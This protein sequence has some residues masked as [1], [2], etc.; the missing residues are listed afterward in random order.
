M[1]SLFRRV[2]L[3]SVLGGLLV[4]SIL[5]WMAANSIIFQPT[6][7]IV[8]REEFYNGSF[9]NWGLFYSWLAN[10]FSSF[11]AF[12]L[13][14][15]FL[16]L[17]SKCFLFSTEK[18]GIYLFFFY[19]ISFYVVYESMRFRFALAM[20]AY[21]YFLFFL[22]HS[23]YH[24]VALMGALAFLLH[25]SVAPVLL[26]SALMFTGFLRR[27]PKRTVF[28]FSMCAGIII[29]FSFGNFLTVL[30]LQS[31][32]LHYDNYFPI[33]N[34]TRY[35]LFGLFL[36]GIYRKGICNRLMALFNISLVIFIVS[37]LM[38][39]YYYLS[40]ALLDLSVLTAFVYLLVGQ[41]SINWTS[42]ILL[43]IFYFEWVLAFFFAYPK[44]LLGILYGNGLN[45][46]SLWD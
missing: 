25:P 23:K 27:M 21:L 22:Y 44:T 31:Y 35:F 39:K 19:C 17:I 9:S 18:K 11:E 38:F 13:F 36:I 30:G 8:Y 4:S 28:S 2:N 12:Y 10:P 24:F 14:F 26:V 37:L 46:Y 5:S 3:T 42:F 20:S 7:F 45:V 29:Y 33:W 40:L 6:D 34:F 16:S 32:F 41:R 43:V 1:N 15:T